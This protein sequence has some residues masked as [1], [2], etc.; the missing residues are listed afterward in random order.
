MVIRHCDS[1]LRTQTDFRGHGGRD[2]FL[3]FSP[4]Q[5]SL[6]QKKRLLPGSSAWAAA[7]FFCDNS[8]FCGYGSGSWPRVRFWFGKLW[9]TL[10]QISTVLYFHSAVTG[11][12][13]IKIPWGSSVLWMPTGGTI[14]FEMETLEQ[15]NSELKKVCPGPGLQ[16]ACNVTNGQ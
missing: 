11:V 6:S 5:K 4:E 13:T 10:S 8:K 15:Q 2:S 3:K 12:V 1:Q 16:V 9:F 7:F 14:N